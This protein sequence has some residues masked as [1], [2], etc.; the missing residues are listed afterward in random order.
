MQ[1]CY[2]AAHDG[3][4]LS[5]FCSFFG[6]QVVA[7][8][9]GN[10]PHNTKEHVMQHREF[11]LSRI[12]GLVIAVWCMTGVLAHAQQAPQ[13]PLDDKLANEPAPWSVKGQGGARG[14]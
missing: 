1:V 12:S 8:D 4:G 14:N 5:P 10:E 2:S 9:D 7:G 6:A 3:G 13:Y 11:L